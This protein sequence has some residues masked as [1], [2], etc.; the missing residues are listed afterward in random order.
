MAFLA[1][2]G[3]VEGCR[4]QVCSTQRRLPS[5]HPSLS[6]GYNTLNIVL[7]GEKNP[8]YSV[9]ILYDPLQK[10]FYYMKNQKNGR[11]IGLTFISTVQSRL[12]AENL[13]NF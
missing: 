10:Y 1:E 2:V 5:G 8:L 13:Q 12:K 7:F 3:E 4:R 11:K 6:G 9:I